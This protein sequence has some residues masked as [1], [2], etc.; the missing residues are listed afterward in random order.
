[1]SRMATPAGAE[2]TPET[3]L[4]VDDSEAG[5]YVTRRVLQ[6]AGYRVIEAATGLQALERA[7]TQPCMIVLDVKLPDISG[8]EVCRRLR[9]DSATT[10][11]PVLHLSASFQDV[12]SVISGLEGGA[13]GY[14]TQPVEPPVLLAYV[15]ALIRVGQVLRTLQQSEARFRSL[16]ESTGDG[17]VLADP[18]AERF[19]MANPAICQMLGYSEQEFTQLSLEDLYP[20]EAF[21]RHGVS[22][23]AAQEGQLRLLLSFPT[24]HKDGSLIHADIHLTPLEIEGRQMVL[25]SF[26]DVTERRALERRLAQSERLASVGLLAAGVAHELNNP[27]TYL[28]YDLEALT[29]ILGEGK[30]PADPDHLSAI[31]SKLLSCQNAAN[32]MSSI[33]RDLQAFSKVD[34]IDKSPIELPDTLH[35]VTAMAAHELR[36]RARLE[37]ELEP[38]P[39]VLGYEGRLSQAFLNLLLNAAQAI[40]E[41]KPGAHLVRVR[42][43]ARSQ[44]VWIEFSDTGRSIPP[45]RLDHIFD[46]FHTTDQPGGHTG[47]GLAISHRIVTEHG[48]RI[49]VQSEPGRGSSFTVVLPSA[50]RVDPEA[51]APDPT[52]TPQP[53]PDTAL[54]LLIVDDEPHLRRAMKR[55]LSRSGFQVTTAASGAEA[56]AAIA[57]GQRFDAILCDLMMPEITGM[58]LHR[59]LVEHHPGQAERLLF[60]TGGTFTPNAERYLSAVGNRVLSKPLPRGELVAAIREL[61]GKG[62]G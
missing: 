49:E 34:M 17:L 35:A 39:Q 31:R 30:E 56:Q 11:I 8:F 9:A 32:R 18:R 50:T 42:A 13:E 12:G 2:S 5:R 51:P 21:E 58:D 14:L 46:P 53:E 62:P 29:E 22:F 45:D 25:G 15:R 4:L 59:W 55:L 37:L 41:G 36:Y 61:T 38:L 24:L 7:A 6:R 28:L 54:H 52:P 23:E 20:S 44:E 48:G 57:A 43:H 3:I 1:M 33:V 10:H 47:L 16:F 26:R 19:L 60:L 27:L 40:D